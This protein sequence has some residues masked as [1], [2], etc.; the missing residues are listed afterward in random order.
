MRCLRSGGAV[1]AAS[2]LL[3]IAGVT[4]AAANGVPQDLIEKATAAGA[5]RVLVQLKVD[6]TDAAAI[7]TVKQAVLGEVSGTRYRVARQLPG[8]PALALEASA[9]TLRALAASPRVERVTEDLP[10]RPQR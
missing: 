4:A 7:E 5:I 9:D 10:R 1:V 8:L 6:G 2:L 3:V